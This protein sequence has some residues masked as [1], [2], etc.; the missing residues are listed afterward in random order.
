MKVATTPCRE[1]SG[2][3]DLPEFC[4]GES[5][6]CPSDVYKYNGMPCDNQVN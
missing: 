2:F 5:E 4:T 3:C 1:A 6:W